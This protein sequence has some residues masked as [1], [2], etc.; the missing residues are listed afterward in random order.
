MR[1]AYGSEAMNTRRPGGIAEPSVAD[2]PRR[3]RYEITADGE[4]AGFTAY[5]DLG[6]QRV[7]YHTEIDERFGGRGLASTLVAAA[8]ADTRARNKR[9]VPVCPFVAKYVTSHHDFDDIL[10]PVTPAVLTALDA[11]VQR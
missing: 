5:A 7:F 3:H 1:P 2:V 4:L 8:L 11:T 10:D 6:D 9:I